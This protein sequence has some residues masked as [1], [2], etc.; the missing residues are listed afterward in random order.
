MKNKQHGMESINGQEVAKVIHVHSFAKTDVRYWKPRLFKNSY[1]G[2]QGSGQTLNWCV[3]MARS[4]RRETF[5]LE[6]P[7]VDIAAK[8]AQ[9]IYLSLIAKGWEETIVAFKPKSVAAPPVTATVGALIDA[10]TRLTNCRSESIDTYA[11]ALRRIAAGVFNIPDGKKFDAFNGGRKEWLKKVDAIHLAE[12]IPSKVVEWKNDQMKSAKTR[13]AKGRVAVTVNSLVRNAKALLSKKV[14]SF[15]E[16]ELVLPSPL[17]FDGVTS[18]PEPSLRYRSMFDG[19][20][21][22]KAGQLELLSVDPEA[23]KLLLLTLVCGLRR[24]EADSLM[25]N[26]FNFEKRVLSIADNEHKALKS[27]DSAGDI[28]LDPESSEIFRKFMTAANGKFVLEAHGG[29]ESD[30]AAKRKSRGYRCDSTHK[31]LLKWLR[32]KGVSGLRPM[33]ALRKEIGSI[34]ASRDGIWQASRYLR[35]SDIGITSRLYADK[36][37]PVTAGIGGWMDK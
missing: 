11:K 12:L 21:V 16:K 8:K 9:Q 14:R 3:R 33:H 27:K 36:K 2:G 32:S 17:F 35:H 28:D 15:I 13:E 30:A 29:G 19:K 23:F 31:F 34:I 6:T 24:S 20:E 22:L 26:Q 5:N 7:N 10:F 1:T 18:E 25:W 4:G 37:H